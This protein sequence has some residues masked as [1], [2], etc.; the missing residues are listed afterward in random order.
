MPVWRGDHKNQVTFRVKSFIIL[1]RRTINILLFNNFWTLSISY[2]L[3]KIHYTVAIKLKTQL[4]MS[5]ETI[6]YAITYWWQPF[7]LSSVGHKIIRDQF[8]SHLWQSP[9]YEDRVALWVILHNLHL[10]LLLSKPLLSSLFAFKCLVVNNLNI[11]TGCQL[12]WSGVEKGLCRGNTAGSYQ[13]AIWKCW[14]NTG[15]RGEIP[16]GLTPS[17]TRGSTTFR[18]Y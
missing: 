18:P 15:W 1:R 2:Q 17:E 9:F 12:L 8:Q 6:I 5:Y 4:K 10:T 14:I 7:K 11:P 13:V 3:I 16:K